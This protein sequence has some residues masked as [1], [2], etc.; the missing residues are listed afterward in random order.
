VKD[1]FPVSNSQY[2]EHTVG[3]QPGWKLLPFLVLL[4]LFSSQRVI[5][6]MSSPGPQ[7]F[8]AAGVNKVP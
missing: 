1:P 5:S 7:E 3:V 6:Q 2:L 8:I 4:H